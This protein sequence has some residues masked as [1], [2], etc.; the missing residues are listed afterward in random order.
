MMPLLEWWWWTE[1]FCAWVVNH[2][3]LGATWLLKRRRRK[4]MH[5]ND[6]FLLSVAP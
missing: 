1:V 4:R 6:C 3:F 5:N 2:D